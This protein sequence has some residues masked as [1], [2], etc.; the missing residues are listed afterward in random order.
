MPSHAFIRVFELSRQRKKEITDAKAN[1]PT[2]SRDS[3]QK[4]MQQDKDSFYL[5]NKIN[6]FLY[7]RKVR[8]SSD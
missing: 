5:Y 6:N 2:S 4:E 7:N 8:W 3:E 1:V